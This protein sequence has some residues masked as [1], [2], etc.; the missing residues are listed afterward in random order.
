MGPVKGSIHPDTD[1]SHGICSSC[2][3][4]AIFQEG[5]PLQRYIDS[6]AIP[7]FVVDGNVRVTAVNRMA[8]EVLGKEPTAIVHQLGGNVFECEYS[9]LPEGCGGTIHCSGCTIRRTVTKCFKT[10]EPQSMV[11]AYL[12]P[13]SPSSKRTL[14]ITTMKVANVVMLRVDHLE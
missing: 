5:V 13:D 7:I 11:R 9:R 1:I 10:G 4:N 3:D 14:F 2:R 6:F 8:C 12:N